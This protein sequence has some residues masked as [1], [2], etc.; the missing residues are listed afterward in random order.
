MPP[1]PKRP[2]AELP[3][4]TE[5]WGVGV[6]QLRVWI[7]PEDGPPTRPAIILILDLDHDFLIPTDLRAEMPS[8]ENVFKALTDI[9]A[10]PP[11]GSGR[12]RRPQRILFGDAALGNALAFALAGVGIASEFDDLPMIPEIIGELERHMQRGEPEPP[13][14][15]SIEGVTPELA[16][17][18]FAAAAEFYRAAPWVQLANIHAIAL[19]YPL[20]AGPTRVVV[21]LGNGGVEYGLA[22]YNDWADFQRTLSGLDDPREAIPPEGRL[23]MFYESIPALP[24]DD[25]EAKEKY[26]WEVGGD[27]GYPI[28]LFVQPD[29]ASRRP[30]RD[31]LQWL[32]VALRAIPIFVREHMQPDDQGDFKPAEQTLSAPTQAGGARVRVQYPAG[33]LHLEQHPAQEAA[34]ELPDDEEDPDSLPAVDRR[35]MEGTMARML[36]DLGAEAAGD[37]KLKKAQKLIYRAWEETNPARRLI[38]AH[39]A[40][41]ASPDCTD[42]YVLLAEEEAD[43]VARAMAYYEKG[44]AAG[45]RVLGPEYFSEAKG[46]FWGLL[47]TRPYM[48]ARQG[49]AN[50]LW[51]LNRREEAAG[52]YWAMLDLNE[53]DN[54]G[55]RY[56]L[57][58]LLLEMDR[59]AELLK[60]LPRYK[61][62]E[63][64]AWLYTWALA[65]FRRS[66]PGQK[67]DRRLR[68]ALKQN[69]HVPAFLTGRN[70]VPNRL[71]AYMGW[72]DEAEA[73]LYA[74]DHLNHWRRT[75]GAVEWLKSKL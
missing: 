39:D 51:R 49:L 36:S 9:M 21:T 74:S 29:G 68:K 70:R 55:I 10:K 63:M 11:K 5:T 48:R 69:P 42:A 54:Q 18:F 13:G 33:E 8:P 28:P 16:G 44:M 34:W 23:V 25:L 26:G 3:Q 71:P 66:G 12:P 67:A 6:A 50:C 58:S 14:L 19:Q 47:E 15:L 4:T 52:H 46:H 17:G 41:K 65:E 62:D 73:A 59:D 56:L 32:E 31:E 43:T 24:F 35:M 60:L 61:D 72:G 57:A 30:T 22:V 45:E 38:L 1:K 40:L 37:K 20:E 7:T 75:P 53:G 27:Q 64:A 2:I